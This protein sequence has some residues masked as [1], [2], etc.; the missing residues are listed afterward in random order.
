MSQTPEKPNFVVAAYSSA[1]RTQQ[2][3]ISKYGKNGSKT[4]VPRQHHVAPKATDVIPDVKAGHN[5]KFQRQ[6][7]QSGS[8][9]GDKHEKKK[10]GRKWVVR[11][12]RSNALVACGLSEA[13]SQVAGDRDANRELISYILEDLT[14]SIAVPV[15]FP[16]GRRVPQGMEL[17]PPHADPRSSGCPVPPSNEPPSVPGV[18]DSPRPASSLQGN[19]GVPIYSS[20]RSW[21]LNLGCVSVLAAAVVGFS[22]KSLA[23]GL[24][25]GV[26]T[27][28]VG[29]AVRTVLSAVGSSLLEAVGHQV[30]NSTSGSVDEHLD[31][32]SDQ[33]DY[34]LS[35][36]TVLAQRV[37]LSA[38]GMS[39]ILGSNH[40][41]EIAR[42]GVVKEH[43]LN[44]SGDV[45]AIS[46]RAVKMLDDPVTVR[47]GYSI[48]HRRGTWRPII[49]TQ[50]HVDVTVS[51]LV[52]T[53]PDL[54][55]SHGHD[56]ISRLRNLNIPSNLVNPVEE[57]SHHVALLSS[58][59]DLLLRQ[60]TAELLQLN[61]KRAAAEHTA[62][63]TRFRMLLPLSLASIIVLAL[64]FTRR[65]LATSLARCYN[66]LL[67]PP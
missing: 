30:H 7:F 1:L 65:S 18:N 63:V 31:L 60:R 54:L 24:I 23:S 32:I 53:S 42:Y 33:I 56:V 58:N 20:G 26:A 9:A 3:A 36:K 21:G 29:R 28:V 50:E 2:P 11:S 34:P 46:D 19:G 15:S 27:Y 57:G 52:N 45:R 64:P 14:D 16:V 62:S 41:L 8:R 17:V 61:C 44:Y 48:D 12:A 13:A 55:W 4:T 38:L 51:R 37:G 25:A 66:L 10:P 43:T 6:V 35:L 22:R 5:G 59:N 49:F 67:A 39:R 40:E 47:V